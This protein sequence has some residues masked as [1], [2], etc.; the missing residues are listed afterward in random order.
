MLVFDPSDR[1]S[2]AEAMT[3]PY[4]HELHSSMVHAEPDCEKVFDFEF[5]KR[6]FGPKR[7]NIPLLQLRAMMFE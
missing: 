4:L 1:I 7:R 2:V 6:Y 5:E 3:H